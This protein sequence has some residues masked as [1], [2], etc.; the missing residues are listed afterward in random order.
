MNKYF[1][2]AVFLLFTC[3][4]NIV[5]AEK[6]GEFEKKATSESLKSATTVR[7]KSEDDNEDR[8]LLGD[9]FGVFFDA[10]FDGI[11]TTGKYSFYKAESSF[12]SEEHPELKPRNNGQ[13]LVPF[14]RF[15]ALF[16]NFESAIE[17]QDYMTE[18][19]YGAFS[20][21][22]RYS[23]FDE[24]SPSDQLVL[25]QSFLNYRMTLGDRTQ[26]DFGFGNYSLKG[27]KDYSDSAFRL[28]FAWV[29]DRH[30]GMEYNYVFT[31]GDE[32]KI[33]DQEI[34]LLYS[35]DYISLKTSYRIIHGGSADLRGPALGLSFHF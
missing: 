22:Y 1:V 12:T 16:G 14:L 7:Y 3:H 9:I 34:A 15:D 8:S 30:F 4:T 20:F 13:R 19:G 18:T 31:E 17:L 32:L 21:S 11:L 28:G 5:F 35:R 2:I 27:N 33:S 10:I 6:L 24:Q 25:E 29:G 23:R 26:L